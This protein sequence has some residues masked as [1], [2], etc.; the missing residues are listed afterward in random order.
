MTANNLEAQCISDFE[1]LESELG[2]L[3]SLLPENSSHLYQPNH[4]KPSQINEQLCDIYY[5]NDQDGR[6]TNSYW[7]VIGTSS[8]NIQKLEKINLLKSNFQNSVIKLRNNKQSD[9]ESIY[10][11]INTRHDIVS[12]SLSESDLSRPHRLAMII[13]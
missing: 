10:Q 9:W 6:L 1:I 7:G 12:Q 3:P 4:F 5:Q 11:R 2:N 8:E 13:K